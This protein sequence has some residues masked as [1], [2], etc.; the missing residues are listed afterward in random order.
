MGGREIKLPLRHHKP[1]RSNV[2]KRAKYQLYKEDL[3]RDFK[4]RCGYCDDPDEFSGGSR[5]YHID[6]FAPKSIFPE[7]KTEYSNLVYSCSY[8]NIA[9]SDKWIG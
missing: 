9:K 2:T 8:C 5:G 6:H 3:R 7:L 4:E 1:V